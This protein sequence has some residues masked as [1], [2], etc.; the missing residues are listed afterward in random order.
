MPTNGTLKHRCGKG[1]IKSHFIISIC[2][3]TKKNYAKFICILHF[4][5]SRIWPLRFLIGKSFYFFYSSRNCFLFFIIGNFLFR[6]LLRGLWDIVPVW[7][8]WSRNLRQDDD[9]VAKKKIE[10]QYTNALVG[11]LLKFNYILRASASAKNLM[12]RIARLANTSYK[13]TNDSYDFLMRHS[14]WSTGRSNNNNNKI[15]SANSH[16]MIPVITFILSRELNFRLS[17]ALVALC[18][19]RLSDGLLLSLKKRKIS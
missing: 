6:F 19:N 17:L 11:F 4:Q 12:L 16:W 18:L 15:F 13:P 10:M 2:I 1:Q 3:A 14:D 8:S 5:L 7:R 9:N